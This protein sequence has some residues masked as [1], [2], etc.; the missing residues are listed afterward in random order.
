MAVVVED[1][2]TRAEAD[3]AASADAGEVVALF[4]AFALRAIE[5]V[6]SGSRVTPFEEPTR[7]EVF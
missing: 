1:I 4:I 2:A 6:R 3:D 7:A 5:F